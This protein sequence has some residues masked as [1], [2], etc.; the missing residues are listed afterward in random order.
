M[1]GGLSGMGPSRTNAARRA[2]SRPLA[3]FHRVDEQL[4][5]AAPDSAIEH[6]AES[7]VGEGPVGVS[8]VEQNATGAADSD[9]AEL[10]RHA[11]SALPIRCPGLDVDVGLGEPGEDPDAVER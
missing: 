9:P 8:R 4:Q 6:A 2:R 7:D 10:L 1:T 11:G 3:V 5:A